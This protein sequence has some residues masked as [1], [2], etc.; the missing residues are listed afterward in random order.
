MAVS[1]FFVAPKHAVKTH[2]PAV[3]TLL[4]GFAGWLALLAGFAH[5]QKNKTTKQHFKIIKRIS[6]PMKLFQI[7]QISFQNHK[8]TFQIY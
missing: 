2:A 7:H 3:A 1:R 6:N 4:A 8:Q 5:P